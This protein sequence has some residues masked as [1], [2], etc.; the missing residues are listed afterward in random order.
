MTWRVFENRT[1]VGR[2]VV[3]VSSF[4]L[5]TLIKLRAFQN[6]IQLKFA[7]LNFAIFISREKKG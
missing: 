3:T 1:H 6:C 5:K 2:R 4:F 7:F